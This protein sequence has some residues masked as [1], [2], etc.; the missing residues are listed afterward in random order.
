MASQAQ[1]EANRANARHSTGPRTEEGKARVGRNAVRHGLLSDQ[2]C[3]DTEDRAA[4]DEHCRSMR[5]HLRPQGPWEEALA[6]RVAAQAWR[7]RRATW[8]ETCILD[9]VMRDA[10]RKEAAWRKRL[11]DDAVEDAREDGLEESGAPP[12]D[13]RPWPR[14]VDTCFAGEALRPVLAGPSSLDVV[15]RYE[16]SIERSLYEAMRAL[17]AAQRARADG[18]CHVPTSAEDR[19]THPVDSIAN[20]PE[21]IPNSQQP[22]LNSQVAEAGDVA[23]GKAG[24]PSA[25]AEGM[26]APERK[27]C[28]TKPKPVGGETV[29]PSA[30]PADG[31]RQAAAPSAPA[32]AIYRRPAWRYLP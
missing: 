12:A 9:N 29:P 2:A 17:Q 15:R 7:L 24:A 5:E 4:F 22:I 31:Q 1:I 25:V 6:D 32:P 14:P 27:I 3:L 8:M 21:A 23:E 18:W 16:R 20:T 30:A 28:E 19:Q 10:A 11:R 26:P 13:A